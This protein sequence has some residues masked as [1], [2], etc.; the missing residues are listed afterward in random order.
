MR[1]FNQA[2][3]DSE[4]AEALEK[5][6]IKDEERKQAKLEELENLVQGKGY[7]NKVKVEEAEFSDGVNRSSGNKPKARLRPGELII[8]VNM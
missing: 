4:A 2:K 6:R 5:Q 3:Y 7:K 8:F 1:F